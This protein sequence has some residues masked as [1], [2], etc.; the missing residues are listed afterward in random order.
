MDVIIIGAGISG[1]A[2]GFFIHRQQPDMEVVILEASA[3]VGG[4]IRSHAC[5]G[6]LAESG[7]HGFLDNKKE[8]QILLAETGLAETVQKAP[9]GDFQ[10]FLCR[11]GRLIA[12]PQKPQELLTT[13]LLGLGGKLRLLG[14]IF[15][16]PFGGEPTIAQWAEYRFGRSV[17]PMVDAAVTGTFSGDYER[18]LVDAVMPGVRDLEKKHGSVLRGLRKK[19]KKAKSGGHLP[20]MNN[21]PDGMES[22]AP[23]LHKGQD[24]RLHTLVERVVKTDQGWQVETSAG[25]LS[26]PHV[27]I[28]LP[29]NG[30]LR[31]LADRRP[32]V[33][34][35]PESRICNVALGCADTGIVPKGFGYLAPEC[36]KRFALGCMFTSRMFPGRAPQ[37]KVLLE[38]LVGGRRHPEKLQLSDEELI[39]GVWA[40]MGKLL[41]LPARPEFSKVLRSDSGIP[42][43]EKGH[44]AL[45]DWRLQQEQLN[46]GLHICGFGWDGIG[47][48][49]MTR[50][51]SKAAESVCGNRGDDG[52]AEVKPVYF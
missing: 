43:M 48:N 52:A 31:L 23:A 33:A 10:R 36:E 38:A 37:G 47:I 15:K 27:I 14:D 8:S 49:D 4:A 6:Y 24:V 50:S 13:P 11:Y 20:A 22:M 44:P 12:L 21:F 45:L 25:I 9:L 40:D 28:A 41:D 39:A 34:M 30:S 51:A 32:P 17:L 26:A 2:A 35:V 18:L 7:P 1:L 5:Q 29:M 3:R 16:K 42:Q 19:P 46:P